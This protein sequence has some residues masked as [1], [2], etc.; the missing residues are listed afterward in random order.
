MVALAV[1]DPN[2]IG[3]CPSSRAVNTTFPAVV[4]PHGTLP[5]GFSI[6]EFSYSPVSNFVQVFHACAFE[7]LRTKLHLVVV[8]ACEGRQ[9]VEAPG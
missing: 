1:C 8:S 9:F 4:S 7:V 3:P 6:T 2:H 5:A